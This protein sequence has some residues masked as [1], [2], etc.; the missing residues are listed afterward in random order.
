MLAQMLIIAAALMEEL[1]VALD[2]CSGCSRVAAGGVRVW[3]AT[4][5]NTTLHFLKTGVG[6]ERSA[7]ALRAALGA[8]R[9]A[10]I[11]IIGY[12]GS[13]C[14]D[15]Q[16]GDLAILRRSS[17]FGEKDAPFEQAGLT[18]TWNLTSCEALVNTAQAIGTSVRPCDGLTSPYLIGE[19]TQ[20]RSLRQRFG[21]AVIDME[22]AA[23][24]R[25]ASSAGI[26]I[27]CVRVVSDAVDDSFLA[28]FSY[29]SASSP[30]RRAARIVAAGNWLQ[31]YS[32][33]RA[34]AAVA[35]R[36]LRRFLTAYFSEL[37]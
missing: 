9:P 21:A 23:L 36:S 29:D 7:N 33:W 1:K 2:L 14:D 19:P 5:G 16:I 37:R 35:R 27:G 26:P 17:L 8:L 6:P 20:K 12:A 32:G 15:W 13:L 22:T 34:R 3:R 18:G 11:L 31:R 4:S 25:E 30:F 10:E 24:A 28:P